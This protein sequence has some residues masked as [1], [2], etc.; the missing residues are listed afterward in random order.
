MCLLAALWPSG[1]INLVC[2]KK[3]TKKA[4][5]NLS[6]SRLKFAREIISVSQSANLIVFNTLSTTPIPKNPYLSHK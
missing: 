5:V 4:T 2:V 6:I 1:N 3:Q